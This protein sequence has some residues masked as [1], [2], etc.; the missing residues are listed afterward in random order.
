MK[1]SENDYNDLRKRNIAEK[2][3]IFAEIFNDLEK[4]RSE[5]K[6]FEEKYDDAKNAKKS[7]SKL[8]SRRIRSIDKFKRSELDL[9]KRYNTRSR[10]RSVYKDKG[11]E[12]ENYLTG[13]EC[14]AD[15]E[16]NNDNLSKTKIKI[17]KQVYNRNKVTYN[18]N[19]IPSADE[20]TDE[21]L[22]NVVTTCSSKVYCSVNG[23]S[24]HQCR[25]KTLDT[26]T[27]CHSG[28]CFGL[29]GQ[30]CGHCLRVRYGEDIITALKD[31]DWVCPPCRG[32]CNCS[33]CRKK[34]GLFPTGNLTVLIKEEGYSS[35]MDYLQF[36]ETDDT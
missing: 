4:E 14:N 17:K 24:C 30:F 13:R 19:N 26:K 29:R 21:M 22:A 25:H 8:K 18:L 31:P 7:A 6:K 28:E 1:M 12:K 3:A 11:E 16:Q 36:A 15:K 34:N 35:V 5:I 32:L 27:V 2:D 33:A 20:I 9:S 10:S 23:T